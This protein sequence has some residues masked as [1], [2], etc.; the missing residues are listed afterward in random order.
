M[1]F[2]K[3]TAAALW[4]EMRMVWVLVALLAV[5][6]VFSVKMLGTTALLFE[7]LLF[8]AIALIVFFAVF[9]AAVTT[10]DNRVEKEE[11][12]NIIFGLDDGLIVYDKDFRVVLFNP[13][14]EKIFMLEAKMATGHQFQPQ[15]VEKPMWRLATQVIFPSLAPS[16]VNRSAAGA[17]PQIVDLS[18]T[19]P[20]LELRVTTSPVSDDTGG[21]AGFMKLIRNRTRE[22]SLVKSKDEFLTVASHQLRS[23]VTDINWALETLNGDPGM[24]AGNK[25]ILDHA[26]TAS[27]ELLKIIEDLLN[28]AKIEEGRFGYAFENEDL[29]AFL[30]GLL[31]QVVPLARRLGVKVYFDRPKEPLPQVMID[32]QKLALAVNNLL[33]N[34]VR[35]NIEN[36]E[37]VVKAEKLEGKPFVQVSIKDT[38]IGIPTDALPNLFK[39]FFRSEN[40]LKFN[41][42]GSGLGLYIA[43]NIIQGHGGAVRA[44]SEPGRGSTFYFTL[45]T[46]P[47]LVPKHEVATEE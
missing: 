20:Q 27:R 30:N 9:K 44:E 21:V 2:K 39:K 22:T 34:S 7:G 33:V 42:E 12:K 1:N 18:F 45:P 23:P 28:I 3:I 15:D 35:Y 47:N 11:F 38:G 36:G 37:V 10:R 46:D 19:D 32:P 43:K 14:A 8:L 6:F 29:L 40:A 24:S 16:V 17:Y 41:T 25:D 5:V 31:A 13:A 4:P 26:L